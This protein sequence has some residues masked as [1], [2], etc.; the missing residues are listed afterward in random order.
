[1]AKETVYNNTLVSGAADE[2]L[3]YTRYVKDESSGKSTKELL[4]EKVNKTDQL[5]TTQIADK[6]VTTEKLENESV[7]TDKLNAASVTTDKVAD[8][9]ITTSKLADSSVETEKINNKAVTTDKLN[10]GAVDNTKLSPNAVTSEKIK[11]ESIITEKLNDRAVTTEKV[12]EKAITNTKIGD[13]AVDGRTISEASVEKKHL[14]NDSVATEKLQ[15][16]AITSDKIHTDA[17][18]EEK[19][20]DSSVSNSKLADNSVGTSKIK[21]GNITNEK[22]ANNTLTLDKL[23]PE[24]R[25]SIQ[26]A[27]GLPENLV[28]VIQDVDKEV[29]TLHSKDTDLQSQITNKQQQITAHDKDIEL[30]QTRSTQMEQT[31]NNIAATGGASVANTV[32]YTN[33]T[34]GLESVNAQGAIDELAAKNKSQDATISAKA[35]AEDVSSQMQTEQ[36]RVNIEFAKKF[37]KESILQESGDAEDKV[38][39]QKAVSDKLSDLSNVYDCSLGGTVKSATLFDAINN[40][41]IQYKKGGLHISYLDE[42]GNR[43]FYTL[44]SSLWSGDISKWVLGNY[45]FYIEP[46]GNGV[47]GSIS[48]NLKDNSVCINKSGFSLF[49]GIRSYVYFTDDITFTANQNVTRTS[50]YL[51]ESILGGN[52]SEATKESFFIVKEDVNYNGILFAEWYKGVLQPTGLVANIVVNEYNRLANLKEQLQIYPHNNG[53]VYVENDTTNNK[54]FI[55]VPSV[56]V[57]GITVKDFSSMSVFAEELGTDVV[58]ST[59][60]VK[61]CISI[62]SEK[63]LAFDVYDNV[64]CFIRRT[65]VKAYHAIIVSAVGGLLVFKS[66]KYLFCNTNVNA[67]ESIENSIKDVKNEIRDTEGIKHTSSHSFSDNSVGYSFVVAVDIRKGTCFFVTYSVTNDISAKAIDLYAYYADGTNYKLINELLVDKEYSFVADKDIVKIVAYQQAS[68][69][70]GEAGE[71][72]LCV[73]TESLRGAINNAISVDTTLGTASHTFTG[74]ETSGFTFQIKKDI[75]KGTRVFFKFTDKNSVSKYMIDVLFYSGETYSKVQQCV[76]A[77]TVYSVIAQ[78]DIQKITIFQQEG[79]LTGRSGEVIFE[80][81]TKRLDSVVEDITAKE[82]SLTPEW[83]EYADEIQGNRNGNFLMCIQ[84]DT[85]LS[86][87]NPSSPQ[88]SGIDTCNNIRLLAAYCGA[89]GIANLGDLIQGYENDTPPD[90]R[91]TMGEAAMRYCY[92]KACPTFLVVGNHDDNFVYYDHHKNEVGSSIFQKNEVFDRMIKPSLNTFINVTHQE[93]NMYY[94]VDYTD[95]RVIVLNSQDGGTSLWNFGFSDAQ[96]DWFK[97]KALNTNKQVLVM[98]HC[99]LL[100]TLT[101]DCPDSASRIINALKEF[102]TG[103][104]VVIGCLAGHTHRQQLETDSNGITHIVFK[105]SGVIAESIIVDVQAKKVKTVVLSNPSLAM[106][107]TSREWGY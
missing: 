4:D 90:M 2:T 80:V 94:Y 49:G 97:T 30:L 64:F 14:A 86:F 69:L 34:S 6:A 65:E 38:M 107:L 54:V 21:N 105:N 106:N 56:A 88:F 104:G 24:L 26:A 37:D 87:V 58:V 20:K 73:E 102:K 62:D 59:K 28:E 5:G 57:R 70:S 91:R 13:S 82:Y 103:G 11:N 53:N 25:K 96:V 7:T 89:D 95:I 47:Q 81:F 9:N 52:I 44:N 85:H 72:T 93:T 10:D 61:N 66:D 84:T 29:K 83:K 67:I 3:T 39:S 76:Y 32:A 36:E 17:V 74:S 45:N 71:G 41:P 1:M 75:P 18:T 22:V 19:I 27:T 100:S 35:N 48:V 51:S 40:V 63:N 78:E 79:K 99:P 55:N 101:S 15:D 16:S 33:T 98:C 60:G 42:N 46:S 23:D 43:L 31:I 8:A 50:I 92:P 77:N 68:A 12:E